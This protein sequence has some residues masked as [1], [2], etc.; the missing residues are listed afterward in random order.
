MKKLDEFINSLQSQVVEAVSADKFKQ[1][2]DKAG[3]DAEKLVGKPAE[4]NG[5]HGKFAIDEPKDDDVVEP[6][7]KETIT[8]NE[9][10]LMMKFK[11]KEP[12]FIMGKA[13]WGKTSIIV[14]MAK[15]RFKRSVI[16]VYLDK[17]QATDLEGV[18]VP[19]KDEDGSIYQDF[20]MPKWAHYMKNH[21]DK[22]FLLFFDEM[23]QAADDVMN[24]LMP[25]VLRNVVSGYEFENFMVGA[26]GNFKHENDAVNEL[27]KP[28]ASRFKPLII[29]ETH[30]TKEWDS[31]F[32][33]MHKKWDDK[34]GAEFIN[35]IHQNC[36]L[37]DN[38]REVE[39]NIIKWSA[40]LKGDDDLYLIDTDDIKERLDD[41]TVE[42]LSR[43]DDNKVKQLAEYIYDY[44]NSKDEDEKTSSR[45]RRSKG[46]DMISDVMKNNVRKAMTNGS[47]YEESD[48]TF[49][50]VSREN[51]AKIFCNPD[52]CEE[53]MSKEMLDRLITK[54]EADG[55]KFKYE[56]DKD[57]KRAKLADPF[58]D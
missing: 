56:T 25:I 30:N 4:N 44:I 19:V 15:K 49:Y 6:F 43:E 28:L 53:P 47:I 3:K 26:A 42:D 32:K 7:D 58:E 8:K 29:W 37:F 41:M 12:F 36:F 11:A 14:D 18:P 55:Y 2:N 16:T 40:N 31:A 17:A 50:G 5:T 48:D 51:I 54:F 57:F 10:R 39:L 34:V 52:A 22:Q 33:Y 46:K 20:A 24:A 27:S 9:K 13:G 1:M 45:S 23:N 35:H 38:P 21:P